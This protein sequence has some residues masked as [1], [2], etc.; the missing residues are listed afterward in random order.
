VRRRQRRGGP[1]REDVDHQV[2]GDG[3]CLYDTTYNGGTPAGGDVFV[4]RLDM[5]VALYGDV[6]KILIAT[7]GTQ[8]LTVNAGKAHASRLHWIL[9]SITG[10][11]PG[12]SLL[13]V[14]IA[15]NPDLYTDVAMGA[16]NTTVFTKFKG[17]LD[18]ND[19]ATASFNVPTNLPVV[20]GFTFHHA[21]VVYDASRKFHLASNAVPLCLN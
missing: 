2:P 21:Y 12:V 8:K 6:H 1:G 7:G 20:P 15:L 5:G 13:G 17:T 19:L 4:S 9:G 14:H 11:T 10:I 16:V 3:W 18:S